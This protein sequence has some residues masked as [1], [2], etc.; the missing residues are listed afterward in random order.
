LRSFFYIKVRD[1]QKLKFKI[2]KLNKWHSNTNK[3][4]HHDVQTFVRVYIGLY[5]HTRL[6]VIPEVRLH[7]IFFQSL[8]VLCIWVISLMFTSTLSY[9]NIMT[10]TWHIN[11]SP[12]S[13]DLRLRDQSP[14]TT[15]T[16]PQHW[17]GM[18]CVAWN[19]REPT[20][21]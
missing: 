19:F 12:L 7:H 9:N 21:V 17:N 2:K 11:I 6:R 18:W 13:V 10:H 1:I 20:L 15:L 14:R 8:K 16:P 5:Y 3:T 4:N